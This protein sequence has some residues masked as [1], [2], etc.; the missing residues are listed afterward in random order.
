MGKEHFSF[1]GKQ[2]EGEFVF[3]KGGIDIPFRSLSDG[4]RSFLGWITDL[5]YHLDTACTRSKQ[6]LTD[7]SGVVLVDEIDLHLHPKWQMTVVEGL[8]KTFPRLQFIFTS[9]SPLVAGTVEW[10][11]IVH[12]QLDSHHRTSVDRFEESIHGLDADQI[13]VSRLF[14]LESTRATAKRDELHD[15]TIKARKGDD[16]AAKQL[17]S[18]MAKGLEAQK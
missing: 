5:L 18:A 8:S 6:D 4:Y 7:V 15:L 13:L 14:G 10:I 11:N 12:L 1:A 9:H 2:V 16:K 3:S 17:I